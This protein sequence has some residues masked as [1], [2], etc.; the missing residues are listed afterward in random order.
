M[1]DKD[2]NK[3]NEE[4]KENTNNTTMNWTNSTKWNELKWKKKQKQIPNDEEPTYTLQADD[5][6]SIFIINKK[7]SEAKL[8][9]ETI[10]HMNFTLTTFGY[11][12]ITIF[13]FLVLFRVFHFIVFASLTIGLRIHIMCMTVLV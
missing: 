1:S 8:M 12:S 10:T 13:L 7:R 3:Q 6:G 11:V 9:Y 5:G 2:R 4:E